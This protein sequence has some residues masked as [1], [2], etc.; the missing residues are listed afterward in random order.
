M[1]PFPII[2]NTNILPIPGIKKLVTSANAVLYLTTGGDLYGAGS[3]R[4]GELGLGHTNPVPKFIFIRSS[5]KDV[6]ASG[7]TQVVLYIDISNQFWFAGDTRVLSGSDTLNFNT[8]FVN[9]TDLFSPVGITTDAQISDIY[10]HYGAKMQVVL[11]DGSYYCSG[12]NN[13][14]TISSFGDGTNTNSVNVLRFIRSDVKEA[15]GNF[16]KDSSNNLLG[17]GINGSYQLGTGNTTST[18]TF[19]S[20][21][22][23]ISTFDAGSGGTSTF[24]IKDNKLYITGTTLGGS[25]I[26]GEFGNGGTITVYQTLTEITTAGSSISKLFV[27]L[28]SINTHLVN[29]GIY[30]NTGYNVS[31]QLGRGNTTNVLTFSSIT[32]V[33][34]SSIIKL[35]IGSNQ[36][37]YIL[38]D[39]NKLYACG[40]VDGGY[41]TTHSSNVLIF[42]EII[43]VV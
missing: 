42:E 43:I 33:W 10:F 5:V 11:K 40:A 13:V 26:Y 31:G 24:V 12:K 36:N 21:M 15:R 7:S 3:N 23:N 41:S 32:P 30:M 4:N 1:L 27:G 34:G 20:V 22:T 38:T 29:N 37:T 18:T 17:C 9:R 19:I 28:N 2:S 35:I 14:T 25:N 16:I 6:W 39:N 8:T